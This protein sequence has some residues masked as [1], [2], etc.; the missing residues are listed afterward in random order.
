MHCLFLP[1]LRIHPPPFHGMHLSGLHFLWRNRHL[2]KR[3]REQ[4]PPSHLALLSYRQDK[5][6]TP[7][8]LPE[9]PGEETKPISSPTMCMN[10]SN[11][12]AGRRKEGED[13]KT[14][15][16]TGD[17]YTL[18]TLQAGG[19]DTPTHLQSQEGMPML[20][21]QTPTWRKTDGDLWHV[22]RWDVWGGAQALPVPAMPCMRRSVYS[23]LHCLPPLPRAQHH[24]L[25]GRGESSPGGSGGS[26]A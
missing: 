23:V 15:L 11:Q 22:G 2:C 18:H 20:A 13:M 17:F 9:T 8:S 10:I 6:L 7:P 4:K 12:E 25:W 24:F 14:C 19:E 5:T 16:Y 1:C 21:V 26:T 3:K